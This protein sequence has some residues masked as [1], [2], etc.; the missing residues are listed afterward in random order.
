MGR[1]HGG[2]DLSPQFHRLK[3]GGA[4]IALGCQAEVFFAAYGIGQ[5]DDH[6][7]AL[8]DLRQGQTGQGI[9]NNGK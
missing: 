2:G 3:K 5:G 1:N 6:Q 9:G 7:A 8:G 4:V